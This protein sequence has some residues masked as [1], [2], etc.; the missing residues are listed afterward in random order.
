MDELVRVRKS[1]GLS[2][3]EL[4]ELAGVS[5]STVYEI[6]TGRRPNVRGSTIH[7]IAVALDVSIMELRRGEVSSWRQELAARIESQPPDPEDELTIDEIYELAD[8][9]DSIYGRGGADLVDELA[10]IRERK[11]KRAASP[12]AG[13][14]G[15]WVADKD[16]RIRELKVIVEIAADRLKEL[17]DQ[18]I[19]PIV[20]GCLP[21]EEEK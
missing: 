17:G 21:E 12:M 2:Q 19:E 14:P 15:D 11:R 10:K 4:A 18:E 1:K 13:G 8:E 16:D 20:R 9:F 3:R 6:E 5:P 7:K